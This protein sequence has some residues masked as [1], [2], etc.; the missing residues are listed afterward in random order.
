MG[1]GIDGAI[2]RF[3]YTSDE[4]EGYGA[5]GIAGKATDENWTWVQSENNP[6]FPSAGVEVE[7][8]V[9]ITY[10]D[11]VK[12]AD[13]G[14]DLR[15]YVFMDWGLSE[16]NPE[17]KIELLVPHVDYGVVQIYNGPLDNTQIT[18]AELGYGIDG[19]L[20]QISFTSTS[21]ENWGAV[22]LAGLSKEW[23]WKSNGAALNSKGEDLLAKY[24]FTYAAFE[25]LVNIG[26]AEELEC[27]V[28]QDW[29]LSGSDFTI[30]LLIPAEPGAETVSIILFD[31]DLE[32]DVEVPTSLL[33]SST[34]GSQ[35]SV[36][37]TSLGLL[38]EA[39]VGIC[40]KGGEN[41]YTGV[42]SLASVG[43]GLTNPYVF[44]SYADFVEFVGITEPVE[45]YVFQNWSG[46]V[47]PV[48]IELI[49]PVVL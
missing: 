46:D 36:T 38:D 27:F 29:G 31:G 44:D 24:V 23:E 15:C 10:K 12:F 18:P 45:Q 2:L 11:F 7:N 16:D 6:A 3:T 30:E 22:G 48:T 26:S 19:A 25:E 35:V 41:W 39:A 49:V 21:P 32:A 33:G 40:A 34:D 14:T 47:L 42:N 8:V 13:I 5:V 1:K 9:T 20:I 4:E 28:F 17:I 37:Y 43:P